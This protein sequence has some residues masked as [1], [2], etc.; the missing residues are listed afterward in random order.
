MRTGAY[1]IIGEDRTIKAKAGQTVEDIATRALGPGM[2]CYV[3]VFNSI[4]GKKALKEG[5]IIKIPK[6][7]LKKRR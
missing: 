6:L 5:Q 1:R 7:E 3:E 4:D 2:S